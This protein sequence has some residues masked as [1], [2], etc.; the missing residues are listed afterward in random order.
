MF[1]MVPPAGMPIKQSDII[2]IIFARLR[3]DEEYARFKSM[4]KEI[5]GAKYCEFVNSGRTANYII[6]KAI[7]GLSESSRNEVIIPAYTCFSVPASIARADLKIR[8]VDVSAETLDYNYEALSN[9]DLSRALAVLPCNLFGVVSDWSKLQKIVSGSNVQL[10]DDSAQTMGLHADPKFSGSPAVAGFYSFGRGKNMTLCS[11][12]AIFTSDHEL[13]MY[14][15]RD[16]ENLPRSGTIAELK[17]L[18]EFWLYAIMLK[19]SLYWIPDNLS[20]LGLGKTIYDEHFSAGKLTKLQLSAGPVIFSKMPWVNSIRR[21]NSNAIAR[22]LNR[23]GQFKVPGWHE[24]SSVPYIR[25]PVLAPAKHTRDEAV[26]AL[27]TLGISATTMYPSSIAQIPG[28]KKHLA[29]HNTYFAGAENIA[30]RLLTL[31]THP[32]LKS[33][34]IDKIVNCLKV[35]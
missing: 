29:S 10:I 23:Q 21:E 32:Y 12:G 5:S 18:I 11:G 33:G 35:L 15:K 30:E 20:F 17:I 7:K 22:A 1:R 27:R 34:D 2:R 14:I 16:I 3:F 31:P 19:P 4:I 13:A 9:I 26:T 28:I 6:L 25:L 8:L 24:N